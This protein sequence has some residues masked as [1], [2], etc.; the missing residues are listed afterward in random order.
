MTFG[1]SQGLPRVL[2]YDE[3]NANNI[4]IVKNQT[5][6]D[7]GSHT[8]RAFDVTRSPKSSFVRWWTNKACPRLFPDRSAMI[9]RAVRPPGWCSSFIDCVY[10]SSFANPF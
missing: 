9:S 7:L 8:V 1:L 4:R 3:V 6:V 10:T 2:R 5:L